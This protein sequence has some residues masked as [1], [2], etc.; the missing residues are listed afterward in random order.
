LPRQVFSQLR[1]RLLLLALLA[2]LPA[3]ALVAF[4]A[5]GRRLEAVEDARQDALQ[6]ARDTAF[7]HR[8]LVEQTR[9]LLLSLAYAP[10]LRGDDPD[11]CSGSLRQTLK[12]TST[13]VN[14][15]LIRPDGALFCSALPFDESLNLSD[16]EYF[17]RA[18]RTRSFVAGNYM[19]GRVSGEP[20]I[21]FALP[22]LTQDPARTSVLYA[23][24]SLRWIRERV[25]QHK[26]PAGSQVIVTDSAQ[27][28]LVYLPD[29]REWTGRI[30]DNT[31]IGRAIASAQGETT[32][33]ARGLDE[34][35]RLFGI[36]P[37][38]E[39]SGG[40]SLRLAVGIP[41]SV[42]YAKASA[43]LA[44][45][46]AAVGLAIGAIVLLMGWGARVFVLRQMDDLRRTAQRLQAGDLGA[47][48]RASGGIAE[49]EELESAFNAMAE[50][51]ERR[52][53][54]IKTLNRLYATLSAVNGT[55]VRLR[56]R[57]AL[58]EEIC[59]IAQVFGGFLLVAAVEYEEKTGTARL[60]A[61]AGDPELSATLRSGLELET[62][63]PD[64]LTWDALR[65]GEDV[66]C[67]GLE[68]SGPEGPFFQLAR[69]R[70]C[71]SCAVLV[72][73]GGRLY[74][75]LNFYAAEPRFFEGEN[76]RLLREIAGDA[77]FGLGVTEK[78]A[79]VQYLSFYDPLTGFANR[80]LFQDRVA[81]ALSRARHSA[82]SMAI[83]AVSV[84]RLIQINDIFGRVTG[85]AVLRAVGEA[86]SSG[87]REGDTIARLGGH[88]FGL[89][90]AD[91]AHAEDVATVAR[92][93]LNRCPVAVPGPHGEV[94]F[95]FAAGVA[96]FPQDGEDTD[97]LIRHAEL[98]MRS[99]APET[100]HAL[101]FFSHSMD[102]RVKAHQ[103]IESGLANAWGRGEMTL[104]Y[105]PVVDLW[106]GEVLGAE[107]LIRWESPTLG[108]VRPDQ[109]IEIAEASGFIVP[110]SE[111]I[112]R[113]ACRQ[114]RQW[115]EVL[116]QPFRLA[117]NI[118]TRQLVQP[119]FAQ[120]IAALLKESGSVQRCVQMGLE[121]TESALMHNLEQAA[122]TLQAVR[123]L[124]LFVAIDDFGTG[125]SSLAYL[126]KLPLD[127]LKID[128]SFV[129]EVVTD[130][131]A[132]AIVK[133]VIALGQNLDLRVVAEG[134]ETEDQF[135]LLQELGCDA[136]QGY[137]FAPPLPAAEFEG[138]FLKPRRLDP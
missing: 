48:A 15:G 1:M 35:R 26:L 49:I 103:A 27:R 69:L 127:T 32:A 114:A 41:L 135:R 97:S 23:A 76:L 7:H 25:D 118:S 132:V 129:R 11:A 19:V 84:D 93:L 78:E 18:L 10:E 82:R 123:G 137:F 44:T 13:Y 104:H 65:R 58:L 75:T 5:E 56:D 29:G 111:W 136:G 68:T 89:L 46:I 120:G 107:A 37:F 108:P 2:S 87:L 122:H 74:G 62:V 83:V 42:A 38:H 6:V 21:V 110:M 53:Q 71:K 94:T 112:F 98:A 90:L 17:Q 40:D 73:K 57:E 3:L 20:S 72:L 91:L 92:R 130:P 54:E 16:R 115:A 4:F 45:G 126:R 105:Q 59:R 63:H 80:T 99:A 64:A 61:H 66:I 116:G 101:A 124:G 138:R 134:V 117:V 8:Q 133:S 30:I 113:T 24:V 88:Q 119:G 95:G 70:G 121:I 86:L 81:Q 12:T 128:R 14:L 100:G 28:V 125:Y 34:K 33:E 85:D 102:E 55:I 52:V 36:V 9:R 60:M 106:T 47:R 77:A 131:N 31:E 43:Q 50:A 109:F 39:S 79:Q 96:I 67:Q 51:L 22:V